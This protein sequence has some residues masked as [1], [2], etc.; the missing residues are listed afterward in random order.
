MVDRKED[1]EMRDPDG[2]LKYPRCRS[3]HAFASCHEDDQTRSTFTLISGMVS[4]G[5]SGT[6]SSSQLAHN[7]TYPLVSVH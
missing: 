1:L 5:H 4:N 2:H 6:M 3:S 7:F